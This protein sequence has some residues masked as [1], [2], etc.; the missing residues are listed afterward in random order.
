MNAQCYQCRTVTDDSQM[1]TRAGVLLCPACS[2]QPSK[3]TRVYT[4]LV[5]SYDPETIAEVRDIVAD[6]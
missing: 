5:S 1:T 2:K 3:A 4:M 6:V